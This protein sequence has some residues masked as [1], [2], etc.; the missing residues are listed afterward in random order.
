MYLHHFGLKFDPLGKAIKQ[1]VHHQQYDKLTNKLNGLL[2][3][4]GIGLITGESGV[5]KTTA[6]RQWCS[7]LNQLTHKVIY[8]ADNHFRP[9]DIYCQLADSL[10]LE[11]HHR[12]CQLWRLL[13]AELLALHD[14]KQITPVW[15]LD[16]ADQLPL[17]FLMELPS[18][19]NFSF[20]TRDVLIIIL[21]GAPKLKSIIGRSAYSALSSR[22]FFNFHWQA[23]DDFESFSKFIAVAFQNTGK[24]EVIISRS[25]LQLI[26]MASKGKLRYAHKLIT[27]CLQAAATQN[28]NHIPDEII[29]SVIDELTT[30]AVC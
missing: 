12:Y 16:E 29:Q 5:G 28:M 11:K 7:T 21:S 27:Q 14:N 15:I 9:F 26:H 3:T 25:G 24:Q 17:N 20:D 22:I 18:F 13:K 10:G 23:L 30:L 1:A 8:Q 4:K 6:L 19:L 2:Q